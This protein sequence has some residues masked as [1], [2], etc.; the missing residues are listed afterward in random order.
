[1]LP[2]RI[3]LKLTRNIFI[4]LFTR[5]IYKRPISVSNRIRL[6][7]FMSSNSLLRRLSNM[8]RIHT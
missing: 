2:L 1:M 6:M 7:R 5:K 8:N 3:P 4:S